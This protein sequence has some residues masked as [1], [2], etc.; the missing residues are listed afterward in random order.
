MNNNNNYPGNNNNYPG[1]GYNPNDP[2][3]RRELTV[4]VEFTVTADLRDTSDPWTQ[5]IYG[6]ETEEDTCSVTPEDTDCYRDFW[7]VKFIVQDEE[8]GLNTVQFSPI[9]SDKYGT[10]IYYR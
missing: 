10:P 3:Q 5:L 1:T 6:A 2:S 4:T 9:G 7:W 8:S